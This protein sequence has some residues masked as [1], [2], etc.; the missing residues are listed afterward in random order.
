[1]LKV[2]AKV[3]NKL[4]KCAERDDLTPAE[5]L[6]CHKIFGDEITSIRSYLKDYSAGPLK[7]VEGLL[8]K[9]DFN[10][11]SNLR[12]LAKKFEKT[13]PQGR[14]LIRRLL[15]EIKMKIEKAQVAEEKP[16]NENEPREVTDQ[17]PAD[18]NQGSG[19]QE[20]PLPT[21]PA[22][23]DTVISK[24]PPVAPTYQE[25]ENIENTRP[26]RTFYA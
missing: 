7:D 10:D 2:R 6:A 1:M 9:I 14:E 8:E 13:T 20:E 11:S 3:T 22:A 16:A 17:G 19:E 12:E 15:H 25:T 18:Q 21:Q 24:C 4:I 26:V 5:A 23:S